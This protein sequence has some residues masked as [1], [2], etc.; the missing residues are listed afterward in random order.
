MKRNFFFLA[1]LLLATSA[2]ASVVDFADKPLPTNTYLNV[3]GGFTSNGTYFSDTLG[4]YGTYNGFTLSNVNNT[5]T[6]GYTNQYAAITGTGVG[7]SGTYAVAFSDAYFNLPAGLSV[8]QRPPDEHDVRG[9]VDARRRFSF[10][11]KFGGASGNDP[12]L[13]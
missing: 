4:Q 2:F 8:G 12:G 6:P 11:K 3:N 1:P 7:G 10:A 9:A 13:L 5:T